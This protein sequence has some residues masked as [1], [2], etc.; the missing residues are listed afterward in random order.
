MDVLSLTTFRH[1]PL[2]DPQSYIR[3]L[4]ILPGGPSE[5]LTC[6]LR[7]W[8]IQTV[9]SY[10]AL[11]YT[12]G[13]PAS[14]IDILLNGSRMTVRSNG[15]YSLRQAQ[16]LANSKY[17]WQDALC[18][19]QSNTHEKNFQVAMM[20]EIYQKAA[21]VLTCLGPHSEDS[22]FLFGFMDKNHKLMRM[23]YSHVSESL[24]SGLGGS[25]PNPIPQNRQ[26]ALRCFFAV[27][28]RMRERVAASY[29]RMMERSYFS[30]VWV[31]QEMHLASQI[32]FCCGERPSFFR[33]ST[34]DQYAG[35]LLD[36]DADTLALRGSTHT[37]SC[38]YPVED[39]LD[40]APTKHSDS[41]LDLARIRQGK[42]TADV[43]CT[44]LELTYS[45]A[46][47]RSF[48]LHSGF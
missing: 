33:Q 46:A 14:T 47:R 26:L 3:L 34:G 4:E 30:R 45:F 39:T 10:C 17:I 44:C 31:L 32:S 27:T 21:H 16:S 20:G 9:P 11:S 6:R 2:P 19:D 18:I 23:I 25:L 40:L 41:L 48:D 43:S 1:E 15:E 35:G 28:G 5:H 8:P 24:V 29:F 13:D 42:D 7:A 36:R 37:G 22:K 38:E 12:W